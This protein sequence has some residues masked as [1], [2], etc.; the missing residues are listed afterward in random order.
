[1]VA[2]VDVTKRI[3]AAKKITC[4]D[5]SMQFK[6]VVSFADGEIVLY[7]LYLN[8]LFSVQRHTNSEIIKIVQLSP[9]ELLCFYK[10]G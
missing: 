8:I 5:T 2:L 9:G 4:S 10:E 7:D 6:I 1:M 3:T